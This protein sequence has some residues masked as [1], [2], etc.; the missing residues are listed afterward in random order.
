MN[1]PVRNSENEAARK[2]MEQQG[3]MAEEN[4]ETICKT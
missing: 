1:I 2:K 4:Y 3:T